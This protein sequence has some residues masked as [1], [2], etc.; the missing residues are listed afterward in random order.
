MYPSQKQWSS[1]L[2]TRQP[3]RRNHPD[4][5]PLL[6]GW[7]ICSA[8]ERNISQCH[9][10]I[11]EPLAEFEMI[12]RNPHIR[13]WL[14][15]GGT[16]AAPTH[17]RH[18]PGVAGP[19]PPLTVN[20]AR[21]S[22]GTVGLNNVTMWDAIRDGIRS[23]HHGA[24]RRHRRRRRRDRRRRGA[25]ARRGRFRHHRAERDHRL[26][27]QRRHR[28]ADGDVLRRSGLP[29]PRVRRHLHLRP[30]GADRGGRLRRRLGGV[31]RLGGRGGAVR[32][33]VCGLFRTGRRTGDPRRRR[34]AA[35]L[36][37][38]PLCDAGVRPGGG[39]VLHL[40]TDAFERRRRA[41]GNRRQG[42][43]VRHRHRRRVLG[44]PRPPARD[45][46]AHLEIPAV[47]VPGRPGAG[48]GD[49]LHLH[50]AAGFRPHRRG[51]RRGE[52]ARTQHP[53]GDGPVSHD[54]TGD[55]PAASVS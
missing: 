9:H 49:G 41:T 17:K 32:P 12:R 44:A 30:Q 2:T 15:P 37:R 31:V 5:D 19:A 7:T 11:R 8:N 33:R 34:Y 29:F 4:R 48:P 26:R 55:L 1:D 35:G 10:A 47:P 40:E 18:S 27:P 28:D 52:T 42:D 21:G 54:R 50:R 46:R 39:C 38:R 20:F 22:R 25:G 51:G 45:R 6:T 43:H 36:A 3:G 53:A 23:A 24:P 14:R 13:A 16:G